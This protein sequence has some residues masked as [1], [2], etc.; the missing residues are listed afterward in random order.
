[1]KREENKEK[2]P[3]NHPRGDSASPS[4]G[5]AGD[6]QV[7]ENPIWLRVSEAAKLGGVQSKTI[8]RGI[9][10][11]ALRYKI[12][13]NKYYIELRTLILFLHK[14]IKLKNKLYKNG[15]GQYIRHWFD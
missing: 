7:V 2:D 12:I 3:Q 9:K 14:S 13:S 1:M 4:S 8:R 11:G 6:P 15:I 5:Q 10:S